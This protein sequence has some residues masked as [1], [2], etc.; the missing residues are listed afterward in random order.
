LNSVDRRA[1]ARPAVRFLA[2]ALVGLVPVACGPSG[3][4][5]A[6][7]SGKVT[8]DGKPVPKGTITFIPVIPAGRNA[9]GVIGPDGSY[10]LQTEKPGDGA[11]LGDY[12]VTISAHDEAVLD[13]IPATPVKPKLLAPA[14]YENPK[15]T[16]LKATVKRGASPVNFDLKD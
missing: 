1:V 9:V 5:M 3:P 12:T 16:D 7:I 15:T 10:S 13:Y 11:L 14:K 6:S 4:E 2:V 8:Y